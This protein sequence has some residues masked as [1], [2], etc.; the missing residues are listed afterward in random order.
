MYECG[1]VKG[2]STI[3]VKI[4]NEQIKFRHYAH[5]CWIKCV[6]I[7]NAKKKFKW[8][9]MLIKRL[10][11][12]NM[13]QVLVYWIFINTYTHASCTHITCMPCTLSHT[14]TFTTSSWQRNAYVFA[15]THQ[16]INDSSRPR[17]IVHHTQYTDACE[18]EE[19]KKNNLGI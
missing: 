13:V 19:K 12:N 16:Q 18:A 11:R 15:R 9:E 17:N 2:W 3:S 6:C 10:P 14:Q 7:V 4:C 5:T 8:I 1:A